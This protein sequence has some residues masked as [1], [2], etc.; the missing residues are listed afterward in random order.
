MKT[1]LNVE[2]VYRVV[3]YTC[4]RKETATKTFV[5][6]DLGLVADSI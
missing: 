2:L 3:C 4:I 5:C 1:M 6:N